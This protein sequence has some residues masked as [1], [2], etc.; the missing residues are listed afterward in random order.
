MI[1]I[2]LRDTL[3][4]GQF[5]VA[6]LSEKLGIEI[7]AYKHEIATDTCFEKANLL[8]W[9]AERV[10]KTVLLS[11]EKDNYFYGFVFPELGTRE[12]PK[13]LIKKEILPGLLGITKSDAKQFRNY[14]PPGKIEFGTSTPFL[15]EE[16]FEEVES[17]GKKT[18]AK[19]FIHDYP[20][21]NSELV[22][23]SLGGSG[24]DAHKTSLHLNYENIYSILHNKFGN[25]INW[26]SF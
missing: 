11:K 26:F 23:I 10:I 25:K 18:L 8:K 22:D 24:E 19:I 6:E 7:R 12:E 17:K 21:I 9:P 13:Y 16:L 4:A 5:Y 20:K 14:Y 15:P 3:N 2:N 1:Q